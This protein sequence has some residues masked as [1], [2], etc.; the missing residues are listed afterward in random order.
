MVQ[1]GRREMRNADPGKVVA[2]DRDG[3][4]GSVEARGNPIVEVASE[5]MLIIKSN[6]SCPNSHID[7]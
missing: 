2:S 5:E 3:A 6:S 4:A 7:W 1:E